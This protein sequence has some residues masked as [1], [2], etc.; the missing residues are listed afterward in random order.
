MSPTI[1]RKCDWAWL[2]MIYAS[3]SIKEMNWHRFIIFYMLS[4]INPVLLFNFIVDFVFDN[5]LQGLSSTSTCVH[6]A[7][8]D[9][10]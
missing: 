2:I 7:Q 8:G 6:S 1:S 5:L 3:N 4:N 9:T 10:Q